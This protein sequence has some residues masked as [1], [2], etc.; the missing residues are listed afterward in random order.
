MTRPA[1]DPFAA[2]SL[3]PGASLTDDDVRAAWRRVAEATHPDRADGGDPE[4][5][6]IAAAAY[7]DLR[8]AYGRG[9]ARVS[10]HADPD[11]DA[12]SGQARQR[13]ARAS[14]LSGRRARKTH[15]AALL[16][17]AARVRAVL[18]WVTAAVRRGRG[19]RLAVRVVAAAS[20]ATI[21]LVAAGHGPAGPALAT[22]AATWLLLTVRHDLGVPR[23]SRQPGSRPVTTGRAGSADHA[24]QD[25]T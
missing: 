15:I 25:P 7:A 13:Q 22:G 11:K 5:F 20:A 17:A 3:D 4:A 24:D 14:W 12:A 16:S 19:V 23:W 1:G 9:E 18:A 2:L 21:G 8:T 10:W 6:A